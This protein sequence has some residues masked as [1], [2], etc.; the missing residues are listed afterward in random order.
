MTPMSAQWPRYVRVAPW[1]L[2]VGGLVWNALEPAD[3]WGDPLL[4]AA[5]VLAGALLPLRDVIAVGAANIVGILVLTTRDGSLGTRAGWL[6]LAN[7]LFAALL[8]VWL[9]RLL[10]RHGRRLATVRSVAEAAQQAV[11]PDPPERVG[12]LSVAACYRAA[13]TEA[14]IGGDAYALQDTPYGVRML[15]ADVRGKGLPAVAAVSVLLGAFREN[16]SREADLVG[17]ADALEGSLGRESAHRGE[18]LRMEGFITALL[19]EFAPGSAELRVLNCGH[20]GPYLLDGADGGVR[21]LDATDP[22]LPLGM[23][24]LGL[25]RPVPDVWPF[26]P[27]HTLL[28]VTDGVTEARDGGGTFYDPVTGLAPLGPFRGP[29]DALDALVRDVERWTGGPRDDDMALL[30]VTRHRA[31]AATM[32]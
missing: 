14:L 12:E 25:S 6:E 8:G 5:A 21:R 19:V 18:E 16:A 1:L 30:A 26:A 31:P 29:H 28:L 27:G 13:Q 4:A 17:L 32:P 22:A 24:A 20:P 10:A 15:I 7:T 9:N 23:G 3:Y 11:L 2:I